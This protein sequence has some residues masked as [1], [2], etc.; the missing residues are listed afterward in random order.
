MLIGRSVVGEAARNFLGSLLATTGVA[1]F[2]LS[3]TFLKRTPGVGMGFLLEV[4]PLFFPLALQFTVPLAVLT[5]VILTFSRMQADGE[6]TS[7][8]AAG[9]PIA[10]IAAPVLSGAGLVALLALLA[11]DV[12][13][14]FAA[15]R[16]RAAKRDILH[17]LET[18]FR[19]GLRDLDLGRG[20]ISFESFDGRE[21][22]DICFEYRE[23]GR[24]TMM[25]RAQSGA[26][27]VTEDEQV[28]LELRKVQD[29]APHRTR[30]GDAYVRS[31]AI[32]ASYPLAELTEGATSRR[33][34]ADL[35]MRQLAY[36]AARAIPH[37]GG[38]IASL[39]AAEELARRTALSASAFFFALVGIPLGIFSARAGRV[40]AFLM[41]IAPVL[42]VYF[43]LVMAGSN[44]AR[45]GAL[46]AFAAVWAGNLLLGAAGA[47]LLLR[48]ARR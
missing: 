44:L 39:D 36:V 30:E 27:A 42:L 41:A 20:R 18:S 35:T 2:M 15:A 4:F 33:R 10:R 17:Q 26:I 21:F 38:A 47:A 40:G 9:I 1:F 6:I 32:E 3:I 11:L 19:S 22:R 8:A 25:L 28:H 13:S 31:G 34:R 43:P 24:E 12:V 46:P 48:M 16:L 37:G 5:G 45:S 14:P 7:L 23:P 29:A